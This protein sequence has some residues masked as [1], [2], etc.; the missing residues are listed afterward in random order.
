[1][2]KLTDLK[3]AL[4]YVYI[5]FLSWSGRR[6][7]R[8]PRGGLEEKPER[9]LLFP[10]QRMASV[11]VGRAGP[12]LTGLL[13]VCPSLHASPSFEHYASISEEETNPSPVLSW[14][15]RHASQLRCCRLLVGVR[16]PM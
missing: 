14:P 7:Y 12:P 13:A 5:A 11:G 15:G 4:T 10:G 9:R 6:F 3:K 1:M 8:L 2:M 16:L